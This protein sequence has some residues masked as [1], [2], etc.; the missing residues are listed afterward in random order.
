MIK[1]IHSSP[2]IKECVVG[3][4]RNDAFLFQHQHCG[5]EARVFHKSERNYSG[6]CRSLIILLSTKYTKSTKNFWQ[7]TDFCPQNA[8]NVASCQVGSEQIRQNKE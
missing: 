6:P 4:I 1:K 2:I 7:F 5:T 8:Q 3:R